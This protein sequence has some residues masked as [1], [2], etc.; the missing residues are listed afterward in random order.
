MIQLLVDMIE[1]IGFLIALAFAFSRS[2]WMRSYM[3]YQGDN[4]YQWRF[5]FFFTAYA[6][7][8]TY[9]G[10]TVTDYSYRSAPW[11]GE[12]NSATAI[13]NSRTVG[14][15]IAGLLGG[16]KSGLIVGLAAGIHRYS[17]GGFVA[18]PCMIAPI[19]QGILAG[20][21]RNTFKQKFRK[22]NSVR[23]AFLVGIIAEMLQMALILLLARPWESSFNLVMLIG[24][25]QILTNGV[26]VALYFV[27]YITM[28]REE[29][30]IGAEHASKALQIADM[31]MPLW[32]LEF[33][34][35]VREIAKVLAQEMR[36]AG[37]FFT[38]D[39]QNWISEGRRTKYAVDLQIGSSNQQ[40]VGRFRLYF[41]RE[42]VD[43][44]SR[45]RML[46]SLA[47][48]L[49]QQYAF[50][51]SERQA[52]LLADAEIRSLQAQMNP[53]FLFNVLNTVKSFIRTKP[54]EARQMIMHLSKF[55]RKNMS[56]SNQR[57]ITIRDEYELV[58]SYLNLIKSRHGDQL[59]FEANIDE[60]TFD[61]LIPPFTIQPLVE[62]AIVHG[63]HNIGR[64]GL[65]RLSIQEDSIDEERL[66]R[67]TVE[68]NGVGLATDK[69]EEQAE[70]AG[71]ALRNIEQRL[72]YHYGKKHPLQIDSKKD[73]GT[74][75]TFWVR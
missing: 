73:V 67:V 38:K 20:L 19:L 64:R 49:S 5:L 27:L 11:I 62:N 66:M 15:V 70:H 45:R 75:I 61:R 10:V 55:L 42:Q 37:V 72:A 29:D 69:L 36:A 8:A 74:T 39:E 60:R 40:P 6:I 58:H 43:A 68:D 2:R 46:N 24:I 65:I 4:K 51:E 59:E 21:C 54:E 17:L 30:R 13:A 32:R 41:D 71:I 57:L 22:A 18:L 16:T 3:S 26:G 7:L 47:E 23:I 50:V 1:R 44:P 63:I 34:S 33:S 14:V 48:L 9:S 53:H 35:A 31:T 56:H 52:Q 12:V 25:P 28:E